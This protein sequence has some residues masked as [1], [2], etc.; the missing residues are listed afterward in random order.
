MK[1]LTLQ[2]PWPYAIFRLGK[3]FENRT[4]MPPASVIGQRIAIHA[5]KKWDADG[6]DWIR[7]LGIADKDDIS[8]M[9]QDYARPVL[10]IV[11]TVLIPGFREQEN[12]TS[13]WSMPY[14][15]CWELDTPIEF[16]APIACPGKQRL[17]NVPTGFEHASQLAKM[18][19][20]SLPMSG[21][22]PRFYIP[23]SL[24]LG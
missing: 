15:C 18:A 14:A 2:R 21:R 20:N 22:I 13:I 23:V 3:D 8:R 11:G 24:V 4:W 7:S 10:G 17:W 1:A 19:R 9:E 12:T 16:S 6:Y 5:G